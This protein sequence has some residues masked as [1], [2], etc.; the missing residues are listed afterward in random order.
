MRRASGASGSLLVGEAEFVV[1]AFPGGGERR[2]ADGVEDRLDMELVIDPPMRR[3]LPVPP[4]W[5]RPVVLTGQGVDPIHPV[6]HRLDDRPPR[7]LD[8][9]PNQPRFVAFEVVAARVGVGCGE[10]PDVIDGDLAGRQRFGDQRHLRQLGGLADQFVGGRFAQPGLPGQPGAGGTGPVLG[11]NPPV[12]PLPGELE[13]RRVDDIAQL[14]QPDQGAMHLAIGQR[15][16]IDVDNPIERV[17]ESVHGAVHTPHH[18]E[19][20]F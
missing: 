4:P 15:G 17:A 3:R 19:Q 7:Q 13:N 16:G 6:A 10:Q 8:T 5:R 11:P 2:P 14:H 1:D 20:L 9:E 18:I 12:R